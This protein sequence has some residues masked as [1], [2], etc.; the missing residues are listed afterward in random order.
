VNSALAELAGLFRH[1]IKNLM[2]SVMLN[3]QLFTSLCYNYWMLC[4]IL[5]VE[6]T[7]WGY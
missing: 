7:L 3:D 4:Q 2:I 5:G 6:S 1:I